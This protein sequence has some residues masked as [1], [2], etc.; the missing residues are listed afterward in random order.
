MFYNNGTSFFNNTIDV[1]ATRFMNFATSGVGNTSGISWTNNNDPA[2]IYVSETA[3]DK[4]EMMF[5]V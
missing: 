4:S 1:A 3:L 5:Q 2:R